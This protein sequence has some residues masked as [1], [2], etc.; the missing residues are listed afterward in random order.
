MWETVAKHIIQKGGQIIYNQQVKSI[1]NT[2]DAIETITAQHTITNVS[3][4]YKADYFISTMPVKDLV[5]ALTTAA[6]AEVLAVSNNLVYR[7]FILLACCS[8]TLLS[9][10][11]M[12]AR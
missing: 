8:K 2:T 12:V 3:T 6:P 9:K 1:I 11:R 5:A 7:D 10:F 4:T